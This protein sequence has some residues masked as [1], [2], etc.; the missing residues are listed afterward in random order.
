MKKTAHLEE[1][2]QKKID[3]LLEKGILRPS[4]SEWAARMVIAQVQ[5]YRGLIR[6]TVKDLIIYQ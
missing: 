2:D 6:K 5:D 1:F 4:Y 3:E